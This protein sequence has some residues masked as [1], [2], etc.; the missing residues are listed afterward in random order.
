MKLE[1]NKKARD[2]VEAAGAGGTLKKDNC[3]HLKP[4][5]QARG[6]CYFPTF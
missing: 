5:W 2:D 4:P 1:F 6:T 3:A